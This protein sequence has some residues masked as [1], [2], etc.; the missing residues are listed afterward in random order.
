V[1][2]KPPNRTQARV[3]VWGYEKLKLA[4]FY[5][6][7]TKINKILKTKNYDKRNN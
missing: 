5:F 4:S 7:K 6:G 1:P 3:V 2:A